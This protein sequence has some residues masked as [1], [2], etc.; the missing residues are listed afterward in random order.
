M[1]APRPTLIR[2]GLL[3]LLALL[4]LGIG[5][6]GFALLR[7]PAAERVLILR[8]SLD[9]Q[10]QEVGPGLETLLSDYM[11]ILSGA[12]VTHGKALP[13]TAELQRLPPGMR[14]SLIHI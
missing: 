8:S 6:L 13:S 4:L 5:S 1:K 7:P 14:L 9:S 11:E 3:G 2:A 12:T 10:G